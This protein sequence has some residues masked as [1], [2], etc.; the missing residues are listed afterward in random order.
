LPVWVV[1][2]SGPGNVMHERHR[3]NHYS[4]HLDPAGSP[5]VLRWIVGGR[6]AV[7]AASAIS[8]SACNLS[9]LNP[10]GPIGAAEKSILIDSLA[11]MLAVVVPTILAICVFAWWFRAANAR[12]Q[13]L[14]DWAYSGQIEM[15]VWGIPLLVILLLGG[16]AWIGAHDLDPAKPLS[17][18]AKP[19]VI[20]VVSLDWKWL[21]LYPDQRIA[22]VNELVAPVGVPLRLE[23]T[24]GSVMT[25]FFAPQWGSMIYTMNG[26]TSHLNLRADQPGDTLGL[27]SHLSG[28][29]FS[30]MQFAARAVSPAAFA[31]WVKAAAGARPPFDAAAYKELQKQ[32]RAERSAHPLADVRLFDDIV[33]RKLPPGPGPSGAGG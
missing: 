21:F 5:R 28:D 27:A 18:D 7:V 2:K 8:L 11:I 4:V 12:A 29:G 30:D 16:V 10:V 13:Y 15:V 20:Q 24:S 17:A 6:L 33:S 14:P 22:S 32:G 31:Y 26:M 9:I 1:K 3:Q 19:I 25:A 23:L